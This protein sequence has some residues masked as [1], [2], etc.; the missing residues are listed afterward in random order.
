MKK[1]VMAC[2]FFIGQMAVAQEVYL[3]VNAGSCLREHSI[4]EA[5]L[6][7]PLPKG[8]AYKLVNKKTGASTPVQQ[9]D[10]ARILFVLPDVLSPGGTATY[11][12][13]PIANAKTSNNILVEKKDKGLL[14]KVAGKDVL[15]YNTAFMPPP[16]TLPSFYARSGFIHPLFSP[17]GKILTDDFP[18]G[19]AHQHGIMTAWVNAEFRRKPIDFWNQQLQ[20]GSAKHV[21]VEAI[22]T[23]AVTTTIKLRLEQYSL[24]YG[25]IL[26]ERWTITIYP[27]STYY[28]FDLRSEQKNIT[29][30]TL[31]LKKYHYGS[32]AFRGSKQ[33]N[34]ADSIHYKSKWKILTDSGANL[35]NA[36]GRRATYVSASGLID[37]ATAGV[38]VFGFPDNYNYPQPVRVHP[39]M[40]YWGFAPAASGSFT[41]NPG[42][43]Y[44]SRYRYCVYDGQ[45]DTALLKAINDDL[46]H[47]PRVTVQYYQRTAKK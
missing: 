14:V 15:F 31:Y 27:F 10:P 9:L 36:D 22:E 29:T 39:Q 7:T 24:L 19:H 18:V 5:V 46:I 20:T 23:G 4:V 1:S 2:L 8:N 45:P 32:I 40:P 41:I 6:S 28:L 25:T 47:P 13:V 38:A 34:D 3:T 42:A 21:S 43:V 44:T 37:G 35:S 12:L 33:W 30:D 16:D 17:S 11:K 26:S